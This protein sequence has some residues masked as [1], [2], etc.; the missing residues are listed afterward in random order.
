MPHILLETTSDLPENADVP[1]IL[2]ALVNTLCAQPD[3]ASASVKAYHS[4]RSQ[5]CVG[6]GHPEGIAHCTVK[7]LNGRSL[8]WRASIADAMMSTLREQFAASIE[9]GE[10]GVSL[11]LRE[12]ERATYRK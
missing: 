5:W 12:M 9:A 4:L 2:Q 11:E 10:V 6:E 3:I 8:D 7:V 1:D